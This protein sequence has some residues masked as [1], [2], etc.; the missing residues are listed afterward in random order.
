MIITDYIIYHFALCIA[1]LKTITVV[2]F[3][4]LLHLLLHYYNRNVSI[5]K[6]AESLVFQEH[7][8]DLQHC[9]QSPSTL[10]G[11]LYAKGLVS[12]DV[13]NQVQQLN[14]TTD[15]KNSCLLNAVERIIYCDPQRFHQFMDILHDE[16]TSR[17]LHAMIM[18]N[19]SELTHH[20]HFVCNP[21]LPVLGNIKPKDL[22]AVSD[23]T[24]VLLLVLY[25]YFL[26]VLY[27]YNVFTMIGCSVNT[28]HCLLIGYK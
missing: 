15:Q 13:R 8:S 16:P 18:E 11:I 21:M 12:R 2:L 23:N 20:L 14:L 10:A 26:L 24:S 28:M 6:S 1:L 19:Y 7:Y 5:R 4:L 22:H 17:R 25:M 27:M 9:I 3:N